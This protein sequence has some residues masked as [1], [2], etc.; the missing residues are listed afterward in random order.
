MKPLPLILPAA[1]AA[2]A[3]SAWLAFRTQEAP[4]P[5]PTPAAP[6][7]EGTMAVKAN[8]AE[9]FRRAFWKRPETTDKILHAE[10]REWTRDQKTGISHWQWFIAVE[11]GPSLTKWL[12][13]DNAFGVRPAKSAAV[14]GAPEW[15]P[16]EH[17]AYDVLT[18][19]SGGSLVL[20][21][22]R[23]G[24]TLYATSSGKGFTPGAAEPAKIATSRVQ[25]SRGRLPLTPPPIPPKP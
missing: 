22:S 25:P 19:G 7:H 5:L 20:L 1:A 8:H 16:A 14:T 17:S 13:E 9:V 3:A 18:G 10:R 11:P 15:F 23:D 21:F 2:L 12:R 4:T 6:Q 24:K